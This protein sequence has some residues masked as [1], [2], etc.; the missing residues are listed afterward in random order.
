M[1][2]R[3][4]HCKVIEVSEAYTTPQ[5]CGKCGWLYKESGGHKTYV[6]PRDGCGF[7]CVRDVNGGRNIL[8]KYLHDKGVLWY[9]PATT[10]P[11]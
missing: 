9:G 4:P 8:L 7:V 2:R 10:R 1:A 11:Q 3:T 5:A 6:C